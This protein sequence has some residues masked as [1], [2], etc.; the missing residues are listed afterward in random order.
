MSV[1]ATET[2]WE[3]ESGAAVSAGGVGTADRPSAGGVETDGG[4]NFAASVA[5][6]PCASV[7]VVPESAGWTGSLHLCDGKGLPRASWQG[8]GVPGGSVVPLETTLVAPSV[9][10]IVMSGRTILQDW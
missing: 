7:V 5:L 9:W 8:S 1:V 3:F 6:E 4:V 10:N 2:V